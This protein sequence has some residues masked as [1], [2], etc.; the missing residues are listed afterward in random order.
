ME[1]EKQKYDKL[2]NTQG[3][4]FM[5]NNI[6]HNANKKIKQLLTDEIYSNS[7]ANKYSYTYSQV[8]T[9]LYNTMILLYLQEVKE[10]N[11]DYKKTKELLDAFMYS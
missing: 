5:Y 9:T 11:A 8:E 1:K 10:L 7:N 4:F 2:K 6:F 3:A